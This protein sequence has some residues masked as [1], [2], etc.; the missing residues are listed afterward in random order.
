MSPFSDWGMGEWFTA[1][2][3]LQLV[4]VGPVIFIIKK[5][6]LLDKV[7]DSKADAKD[8]IPIRIALRKRP[9]EEWMKEYVELT[10][11]PIKQMCVS[12]K[13]DVGHIRALLENK[14]R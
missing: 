13:E 14:E 3:I 4:V 5:M 10:Q 1:L 2:S 7:L 11:E 8:L 12:I 6:L 9:T